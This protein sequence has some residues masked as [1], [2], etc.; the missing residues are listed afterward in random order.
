MEKFADIIEEIEKQ[1]AVEPPDN[2]V[3]RIM[4]GVQKVESGFPYK[5]NRF[6][7]QPLEF[8]QDM[9]NII[10]GQLVSYRQCAFLLFIVGLFYLFSGFLV[11]WGLNDALQGGNIN[12]WL[13]IQPY[14]AVA[15]AMIIIILSLL[16]LFYPQKMIN[17]S[18]YIVIIHIAFIAVNAIILELILFSRDALIF[19]ILL[20]TAAIILGFLLINYLQSFLKNNLLAVRHDCDQNA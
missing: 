9:K 15:S 5:F 18:K 16:I 11:M 13:R 10:S 1:K 14:I 3:N 12:S 20:A 8:S 2:L 17:I 6:L 7:F 19:T 4:A